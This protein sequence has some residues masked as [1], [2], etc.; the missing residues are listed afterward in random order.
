MLPLKPVRGLSPVYSRGELN[1]ILSHFISIPRV[2]IVNVQVLMF[3]LGARFPRLMSS[4]KRWLSLAFVL[5]LLRVTAH[6]Q[7]MLYLTSDL[8]F[9]S[10]IV[11]RSTT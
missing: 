9:Q 10:T 7:F 2:V 6:Q 4:Q 3:W 11:R 8:C 1:V 5:S